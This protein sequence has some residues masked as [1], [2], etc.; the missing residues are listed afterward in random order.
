MSRWVGKRQ[1]QAG[2]A[3]TPSELD[4]LVPQAEVEDDDN[5]Y[6]VSGLRCRV[7]ESGEA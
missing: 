3:C 6:Y 7:K 5:V 4:L 2:V 1:E